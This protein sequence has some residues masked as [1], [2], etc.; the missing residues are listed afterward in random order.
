MS[1]IWIF[2]GIIKFWNWIVDR[3]FHKDSGDTKKFSNSKGDKIN[4]K[5]INIANSNVIIGNNNNGS[6]TDELNAKQKVFEKHFQTPLAEN[7]QKFQQKAELLEQRRSII[8]IIYNKLLELNGV[9]RKESNQQKIDVQIEV[10][11]YVESKR[12]FLTDS[13]Y[14]EIK[15]VQT[16]MASLSGIYET[17][18]KIKGPTLN[19]YDNQR[20][21]LETKIKKQLEELESSFRST[22]VDE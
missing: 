18:N 20:I 17:T 8:P 11:N 1:I 14:K 6:V 9:I 15:D 5:D 4:Y 19:I 22:M 12:L 16:S 3:L 7:N 2:D 10:N 21:E 13:L